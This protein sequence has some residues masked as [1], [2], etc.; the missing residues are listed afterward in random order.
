MGGAISPTSQTPQKG[1]KEGDSSGQQRLG[2]P[3]WS[4]FGFQNS[5]ALT[6]TKQLR[7][8]K[9]LSEGGRKQVFLGCAWLR[10]S[11]AGCPCAAQ[12]LQ[13]W[14]HLSQQNEHPQ[15]AG[16]IPTASGDLVLPAQGRNLLQMQGSPMNEQTEFETIRFSLK[17]T[18][19]QDAFTRSARSWYWCL[20]FQYDPEERWP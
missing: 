6:T 18:L 15:T 16:T 1:P 11:A 12:D 17:M 20:L 9:S 7:K 8:V 3:V 13:P 14:D 2:P 19:F 10:V 5:K 4:N